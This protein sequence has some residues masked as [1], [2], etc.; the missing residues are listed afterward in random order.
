MIGKRVR[1]AY[2]HD[3]HPMVVLDMVGEFGTVMERDPQEPTIWLVVF[4]DG[5]R[6][7]SRGKYLEVIDDTT[8]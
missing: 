4:E 1:L 8:E 2:A 3:M 7:W 5:T 6:I